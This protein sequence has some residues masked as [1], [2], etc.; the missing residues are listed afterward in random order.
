[1]RQTAFWALWVNSTRVFNVANIGELL[2][3]GRRSDALSSGN[4]TMGT[5]SP[6]QL[7]LTSAAVRDILNV[8]GTVNITGST[9]A[10]SLLNYTG[11]I[12]DVFY[13]ILNDAADPVVGTFAGLA[14]QS[15]FT[16]GRRQFQISYDANS[17]GGTFDTGGNDVALRNIPE[18]ASLLTMLS[19]LGMLVGLQRFRR[20][21]H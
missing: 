4:L 6:L 8:T 19:G 20:V 1:L 2:T 5:G 13:V 14:D 9:L 10:V 16:A 15:I 3:E 21:R 11:A 12:N 18:P 7:E 17:T